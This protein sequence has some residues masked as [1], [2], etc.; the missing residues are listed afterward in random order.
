MSS[1]YRKLKDGYEYQI[2]RKF[3]C[4][5]NKEAKYREVIP[6]EDIGFSYGSRDNPKVFVT[7]GAIAY[8]VEQGKRQPDEMFATRK[9][10]CDAPKSLGWNP[11]ESEIYERGVLCYYCEDCFHQ[12]AMDI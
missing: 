7:P 12:S 5:R 8:W 3:V 9:C 6:K 11:F 10:R 4:I 1:K 2:G